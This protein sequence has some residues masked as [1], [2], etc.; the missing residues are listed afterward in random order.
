MLDDKFVMEQMAENRRELLIQ[1]LAV[2]ADMTAGSV[3]Q[4][5]QSKSGRAVTALCWKAE[6]TMRTAY[7]MQTRF[8][9]VP[10]AQLLHAKHGT[11][12]P[13]KDDELEWHLSYFID[14]A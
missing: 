2:M 12:Y 13:I 3:R 8:A 1:C 4:V 11:K 6:L 5:M 7:E 14:Q 10:T 9:L